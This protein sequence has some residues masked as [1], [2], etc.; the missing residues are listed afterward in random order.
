MRP[1]DIVVVKLTIDPSIR[2]SLEID[3]Y[4]KSL[5]FIYFINIFVFYYPEPGTEKNIFF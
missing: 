1:Q 5:S 2:L 4:F 3:K